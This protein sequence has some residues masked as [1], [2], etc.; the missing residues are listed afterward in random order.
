MKTF[1]NEFISPAN[2]ERRKGCK[3]LLRLLTLFI[4]CLVTGAVTAQTREELSVTFTCST[5]EGSDFN[6]KEKPLSVT[7]KGS[8]GNDVTAS[9]SNAWTGIDKD[10]MRISNGNS[11]IFTFKSSTGFRISK[12]ALNADFDK[13]TTSNEITSTTN[14]ISIKNGSATLSLNS[15]SDTEV[16][17][18]CSVSNGTLRVASMT[19][20]YET[21]SPAPTTKCTITPTAITAGVGKNFKLTANADG[22][23]APTY[24]WYSNTSASNTGG[25]SIG[26]ATSDTDTYTANQEKAGTYYYYC[27]AKNENNKDNGVASEVATVTVVKNDLTLTADNINFIIGDA[28]KAIV[29]TAKDGDTTVDGLTYSYESNNTGVAT[30]DESGNVTPI[31]VGNAQITVTFAG[32]NIYNG[33]TATLNVTV[34]AAPVVVE[35]IFK[36]TDEND[37][38]V[39]FEDEN[40]SYDG[41]RLRLYLSLPENLE[42]PTNYG[43]KYVL[44]RDGEGSGSSTPTTVYDG[45]Y[46]LLTSTTFITALVYN[47]KTGKEVGNRVTKDIRF[48]FTLLRAFDK[49]GMVLKDGDQRN[50]TTN[51][52]ER[53]YVIATF[54]SKDDKFDTSNTGNIVWENTTY[55]T[56]MSGS[57]ISDFKYVARGKNDAKDENDKQFSGNT[58]Y[59]PFEVK[60]GETA[61]QYYQEASTENGTFKIPVSGAYI[62]F[63]PKM[64]GTINVILRQNGIIADGNTGD[65]IDYTVMRKRHIYV[66]DE[67][68]KILTNVRAFMNA[69]SKMNTEIFGFGKENTFVD[70]SGDPNPQTIEQSEEYFKLYRNLVYRAGH[71]DCNLSEDGL[72]LTDASGNLINE[73]E[74][75]TYWTGDAKNEVTHN[76]LYKDG[77]GWITLSKAYVRYS[78]DVKPGKTYFI[79]GNVTKV[80]V[81]GY[82]FKRLIKNDDSWA[83]IVNKRNITISET[84]T[85]LPNSLEPDPDSRISGCNVTLQRKFDKGVWTSIVL[86]FSVSPSTLEEAFGA[87]TEIIHFGKVEGSKLNLVKHYHQMIVA[88]TPVLIRP[89]NEYDGTT[90]TDNN[91]KAY[92]KFS[93]ITYT[94]YVPIKEMTGG[95]WKVTGSY[96][97]KEMPANSYYVGYKKDASGNCINNNIYLAKN[98]RTMNGTRAWFEYIGSDPAAAKLTGL[99]INGVEDGETTDIDSILTEV[100]NTNVMNGNVYNLNGQIVSRKG[101][102]GL[103]KGIYVTNGKKIIVK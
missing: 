35:P 25:E 87:G 5:T 23:P 93:N 82:S 76:I 16:N 9:I 14:N 53:T 72:T 12:I 60:E 41:D 27:V 15:W 89:T 59:V 88:G 102:D 47:K 83:E 63:E 1:Y 66:C 98:A 67:E 101:I 29:V 40:F 18:N 78:F 44:V 43:I 90:G 64:G 34:T 86:P 95:N 19:V 21:A 3:T 37:N 38:P 24:Q 42:N 91:K 8:D 70:K 99:S 103:A 69:N 100:E 96:T 80:G 84:E 48:N 10:N 30:V 77:N 28:A 17:I 58:Q 50:L 39:N 20:Y 2:G 32:D 56:G 45:K 75:K 52:G 33:V 71:L 62:K 54:G 13:G 11:R 49:K 46:I 65:K 57:E 92:P 31:A 73:D 81:C 85:K 22:N 26:G 74:T 97:P 51:D 55:D 94:G 79:M 61:P 4:M 6:T 7:K 68:G 36:V